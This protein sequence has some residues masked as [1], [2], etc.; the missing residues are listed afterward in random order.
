MASPPSILILKM[1]WK[2][3]DPKKMRKGIALLWGAILAGGLFLK[4]FG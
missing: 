2:D 3:N 1:A 4:M